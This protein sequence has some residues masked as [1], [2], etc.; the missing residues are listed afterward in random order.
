MS[1][2]VR[3]MKHPDYMKDRHGK[4]R[5]R[6]RHSGKKD[7]MLPEEPHSAAFDRAYEAAIMGRAVVVQMP[8]G[9]GPR[10]APIGTPRV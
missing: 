8:A 6:L 5:W 7:V 4:V 9:A 1:A 10:S 3:P 2:M